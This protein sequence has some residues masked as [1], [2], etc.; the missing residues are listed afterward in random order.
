M[1]ELTVAPAAPTRRRGRGLAAFLARR[2]GGAL[3]VLWGAAT[4]SFLTLHVIPGDPVDTLLGPN[5]GVSPALRAEI[6][7]AY[8]FD[9]PLAA[10][11]LTFLGRLARGDLGTS[12]QLQVPVGQLVGERL[13]PTASLALA[14]TAIAA[15]LALAAALATAGRRGPTRRLVSGLELVAV[16]SP[17]FWLGILLVTV[18]SVRLRLF[19]V[20]GAGGLDALVL[21]A[22]ALALPL[23]GVLAQ[24]LRDGLDEALEAPF[25][26][27]VRSRGAGEARVVV[28]HALRHAALPLV[29]LVGWIVGGLFG[30][31]VVTETLFAR[32]GV[33][34]LALAAVTS[35]DVPVVTAVVLLAAVDLLYLLIDPRLRTGAFG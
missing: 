33:G 35:R 6:V 28:V 4:L 20:S 9:R 25:V 30:G 8:G 32:P 34:R 13:W 19:P 5:V 21:P 27:T 12:Y 10:Q 17:T 16:A 24:V 18:F 7:H 22:T 14:A 23:A 1:G 2:A 11:Y 3:G 29:T 15:V 26:V 31:A